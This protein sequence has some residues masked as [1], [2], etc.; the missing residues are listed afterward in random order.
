MHDALPLAGTISR[1][2]RVMHHSGVRMSRAWGG[3]EV[4]RSRVV[5]D[6]CTALNG[7]SALINDASLRL[8]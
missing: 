3:A 1:I 4:M 6:G 7:A 5:Y 8:A 2:C